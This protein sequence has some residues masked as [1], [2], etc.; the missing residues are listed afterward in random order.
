MRNEDFAVHVRRRRFVSKIICEGVVG[1]G[2]NG[3]QSI[4]MTKVVLKKCSCSYTKRK[5][6]VS[7]ITP[8]SVGIIV[9]PETSRF[10]LV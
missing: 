5:R 8:S 10:L 3:N 7:G 6:D 2:C 1:G 9:I 4:F